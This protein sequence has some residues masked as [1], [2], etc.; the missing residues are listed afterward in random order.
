MGR[1]YW[2]D[3]EKHVKFPSRV[4]IRRHGLAEWK[5]AIYLNQKDKAVVVE[6]LQSDFKL[7]RRIQRRIHLQRIQKVNVLSIKQVLYT[8]FRGRCDRNCCISAFY[9]PYELKRHS[10]TEVVVVG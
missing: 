7:G 2:N 8:T 4:L 5:H 10:T 6:S 3:T 9:G 1:L